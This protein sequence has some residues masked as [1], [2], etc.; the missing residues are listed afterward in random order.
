MADNYYEILG[1]E[2]S[3]SQ[4]EIKKAY[5]KLAIK[6]HPDKNPEDKTAEEKFKK[7]AEAYEVLS[8][9]EK[10]SNFDLFGDPKGRSQGGGFHAGGMDDILNQFRGAFGS[11]HAAQNAQQYQGEHIQ[12]RMF[13]SLE[14]IQKGVNKEVVYTKRCKCASCKGNGSKDGA[15]LTNCSKC[16]GSGR[17]QVLIH[18]FNMVT[19][20][21]CDHCGGKG[22]LPTVKCTECYGEGLLEKETKVGVFFPAGVFTGW[23]CSLA[24][25][26]HES[27]MDNSIPGN[28]FIQIQ[29]LEHP[30]FKREGDNIVYKI[31][32]N[33]PDIILG[34]KVII[35]TLEKSVAFDIPP[36][37]KVNSVFQIKGKGLGSIQFPGQIGNLLVEIDV[38][39]P[40]NVSEEEIKVLQDLQKSSNFTI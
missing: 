37:S 21:P 25:Y 23:R 19:I 39:V 27:E 15:N 7:I 3:A 2:K 14:D 11:R 1:I 24:G 13:L 31:K 34:K 30:K 36:Y 18:A 20:Q 16:G 40:N 28:L 33:F 6:Y 10:K 9:E 8:D 32:V 29:E 4:E 22:K 35:P 5:R 12:M 38:D 17:L 26:G